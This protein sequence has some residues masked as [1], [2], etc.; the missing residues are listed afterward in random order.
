[1]HS[2][3]EVIEH[4]GGITALARRLGVTSQAISQWKGEIPEPRGYQI[5]VLS[6]GRF[7]A[8]RLPLRKTDRHS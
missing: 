4:F 2:F 5:E 7:K 1:M 8:D 6:K 3:Q